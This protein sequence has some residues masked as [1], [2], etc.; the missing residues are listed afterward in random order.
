MSVGE[1]SRR[2]KDIRQRVI[3]LRHFASQSPV[4][5][6]KVLTE[7]LQ[8]LD[9]TLKELQVF[10]ESLWHQNEELAQ[11]NEELTAAR[12]AVEIERQHYQALFDFA[13]D[14][15]LVTDAAGTIQQ[16]N[17]A[18]TLL[19]E[20]SSSMLT[21]QVLVG[22]PLLSFVPIE[23]HR[24]FRTR[25]NQLCKEVDTPREWEGQLHPAQTIHLEQ[26]LDVALKVATVRCHAGKVVA[27]RWLVRDITERK[28]IEAQL[29]HSAFHDALTGLP[30]R[31][32]FVDRL[33]H[34][35]ARTQ[36][37]EHDLFAV[38]FIDLDRFKVINDSLGH[39]V[40]DQLLIGISRR[41][42]KCLRS[43]DTVARLGG[44]E[45]A[46]LLESVQHI[47]EATHVANRIRNELMM[48]FS[49]SGH[50]V[51]TT[52]S[53]GIVLSSGAPSE[54]G[55][56]DQPEDLLRDADSAM[57]CAKA[58]GSAHYEIFSTNMYAQA[59]TRLQVEADLR[60]GIE[61]QEFR[62]HYQPIVSLGNHPK[63]GRITG[64]EALV[65][66]QHPERGLLYPLE[67]MPVA[68]EIGLSIP[69]DQWVLW[70][71]C[72][73]VERWQE[74]YP[75]SNLTIS[76]NLCSSQFRHPELVKYVDQ[77]LRESDLAPPTLKL[78]ILEN[79]IMNNDEYTTTKLSQLKEL[80]IQ[81]AIDDFGTGY[82]SLSR[83]Q[84]FPI[85][86][87]KID[88]SFMSKPY[89]NPS[90]ASDKT[91]SGVNLEITE[92]IIMLAIKLGIDVTAEGVETA[93]Q[94][95]QL[96]RLNCEYGQGYF[97]SQPLGAQ[98]AETLIMAKPRW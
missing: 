74:R 47:D 81:L 50:E 54:A 19:L 83:L 75:G 65:R 80:G 37:N 15:Y 17:Q 52:A 1:V 7:A 49:L 36:R 18:A 69:I 10:E 53:I 32:L 77:A 97:F 5:Q 11:R 56:Y 87:L 58:Q 9:L 86:M 82:S 48:P 24:D 16:A 3:I 71:A 68:E 26:P 25:L 28:Q 21:P 39:L 73:Q 96:R 93:E 67:F 78:E 35:I 61:R 6:Q 60:R 98:A 66:W 92:T 30:N 91:G 41:L 59:M 29:L 44:D 95:A 51:F 63:A 38:L 79:T 45:F 23:Q 40:G 55:S 31:A 8:K 2:L 13:P 12:V 57:Y 22:K 72:H 84:H 43:G 42:E 34:T 14:S 27:L 46:V 89:T 76:V 94:L 20:G 62:I 85:D 88:R 70:E 4:Q 90:R 64:F 33:R